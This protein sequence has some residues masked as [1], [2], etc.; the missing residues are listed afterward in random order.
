YSAPFRAPNV[1]REGVLAYVRWAFSS[2]T[3]QQVWFGEPLEQGDRAL[4]E[5]W[6]TRLDEGRQSTLAGCTVLRF[7]P[8]GL[9]TEARNYWHEE[10]GRRSRP[11]GWGR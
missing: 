10:D 8:D 6:T 7:G 1:G 5:W 9:V 3:E 2:E 4:V 11:E